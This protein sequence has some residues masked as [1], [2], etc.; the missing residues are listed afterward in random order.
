MSQKKRKRP[1]RKTILWIVGILFVL[2]CGVAVYLYNN[3]NRLLT[4]ALVKSFNSNIISDVYELKFDDLSVDLLQGNIKVYNVELQPRQKP[5]RDYSYI[6]SSF[7]LKTQKMRLENVQLVTL[8]KK[9]ILNLDRI[10]I[11]EPD[12]ELKLNGKNYIL[13]P[14][15]DTTSSD[16]KR[17]TGNKKTLKS[18]SLKDFALIN[19]AFHVT[20]AAKE[21]DFTIRNLNITLSN[22]VIDQLPGKLILF[23]RHIDLSIGE[24]TGNLRNNALKYISFKDYKTTLDSV[25]IQQTRDTAIKR[26]VDF[27]TVLK[28]LDIQTADSIVH[29]A[30]E[31]FDLSWRKKS[32]RLEGLSFKPNISDAAMQQR[33]KFQNTQFSGTVGTMSLSGV[34]FDSLLYSGKLLIDKIAL[35]KLSVSLF[36][37]HTKPIDRTRF[38]QYLG[39]TVKAI[40]IPLLIKQVTVTNANLVNKERKLDGNMAIA[41][42]NRATIDAR[43]ISSLSANNPL[44]INAVAYIENKAPVN[45]TLAFSY[46]APQYSINGRIGKFNL[47]DLNKLLNYYAPAAAIKK[48]IVDEITFSGIVYRTNSNGTMKFLYHD[49]EVDLELHNK[50][51]WKSSVLAFAANTYLNASNPPSEGVPFRVVEFKAERDMYKGF[52]NILIKSVLNGLK[53]TLIMSKE[54]RKAYKEVKKEARKEARR[55]A[56]KE[57][58]KNKG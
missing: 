8:I 26:F 25:H 4:N 16:N 14:L 36:K 12:V 55:E 21:R 43:N 29:L 7:H 22:L 53:E 56:R 18:F 48:G 33:F 41:N 28:G 19:A 54:N 47:Q 23:N 49:L 50:A 52:V 20:N 13:F 38:P 42:I 45:L 11:T 35:D 39:Q 32:I 44:T 5:L 1:I 15:P 57:R 9:N 3:L 6:N 2:I 37:D 46:L 10:V 27:T 40:P 30:M 58:K 31:S 51:E 17:E 24:F 34:N